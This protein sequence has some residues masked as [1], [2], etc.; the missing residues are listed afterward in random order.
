[1]NSGP[2]IKNNSKSKHYGSQHLVHGSVLLTESPTDHHQS[3]RCLSGEHL[4][5]S[6]LFVGPPRPR[7]AAAASFYS[8]PLVQHQTVMNAAGGIINDLTVKS[9][10][11]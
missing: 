1:M 4:M 10:R 3:S 8:C 5:R 11:S 2:R 7:P 9:L 6:A